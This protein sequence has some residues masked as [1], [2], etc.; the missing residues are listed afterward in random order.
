MRSPPSHSIRASF[1]QGGHGAAM[2]NTT[3]RLE[4][5]KRVRSASGSRQIR[6]IVVG[7]AY[8]QSTR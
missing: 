7:T 5:S 6:C 2:W 3:R 1:S 4:R 8:I